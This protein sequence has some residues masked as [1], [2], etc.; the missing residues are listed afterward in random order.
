MQRAMTVHCV[1]F[2]VEFDRNGEVDEIYINGEEVSGVL[3]DLTESA[4]RSTVERNAARWFDEYD[5]DMAF[6]ARKAA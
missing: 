4:I 3:A 5:R 2:Q 1:N 6:F